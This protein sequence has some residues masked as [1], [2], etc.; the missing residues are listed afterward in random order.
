MIVGGAVDDLGHLWGHYVL[1]ELTAHLQAN[2]LRYW[3]DKQGHEVDLIWAPL[4]ENPV[5]IECKWSAR[6]FNPAN[7]LV[8]SR[9]YPNATLLVTAPD[10]RPAYTRHYGGI[11]VQFLTLDRLT[12]RIAGK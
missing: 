2:S 8:F 12:A 1:Y 9:I 3:R 4:G 10:A 5:A 11:E 6:D 7:R